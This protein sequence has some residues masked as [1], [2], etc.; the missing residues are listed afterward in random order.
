MDTNGKMPYSVLM[1]LYI[2]EKPAYFQ[3][4]LESMLNQTVKP[5]QIVIVQDGPLT[6]RLDQ[7]LASYCEQYPDLI[8]SVPLDENRGLGIALQI[9]MA[10]CKNEL[11]A[12]MDT[13]DIAE[14]DRCER[15][16][17]VFASNPGVGLVGGQIMEFIEAPEKPV[18]KRVVPESD[19]E[20]RG[21]IRRRNPFNHMTVMF[22]KSEVERAGGYMDWFWGEDYFLWLRMHKA[23][24]EFYNLPHVLVRARI[25]A[26]MYRRRGGLKYFKS[27]AKLMWFARSQ[28]II[29]PVQFYMN[30]FERLV[31]TVLMP[32]WLRGVVFRRFV[33]TTV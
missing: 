9:G 16:L 30:L 4:A 32:Q 26:D 6:E 8:L 18:A 5:D 3:E 11:I 23:G 29:G 10:V 20:I 31:V 7:V 27:Q 21:F 17:E 2:K 19:T 33:R 24:C 14:P 1:S 25:G 13:D 22:K 15:Q 12:R 28:G